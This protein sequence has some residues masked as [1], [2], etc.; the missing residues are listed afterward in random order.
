M[1]HVVPSQFVVLCYL[2]FLAWAASTDAIEFKIPNSATLGI[3]FLYPIYVLASRGPVDWPGALLVAVGT[4]F[5]GL[6]LFSAGRFGGGDVKL[7][8]AVA[9]WAGPHFILPLLLTTG[10]AG[11]LLAA[12]VWGADRLRRQRFVAVGDISLTSK[13]YAPQL[14][15]PYG[16][17]IAA[18]AGLVGLRLLSG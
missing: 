9:L 10:I 4:F 18:G 14:Y 3:V 17:A 13:E 15:L 11:G 12:L 5:V 16:V 8:S 1:F 2:S 7:L 6:M